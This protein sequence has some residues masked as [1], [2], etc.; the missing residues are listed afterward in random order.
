MHTFHHNE[1]SLSHFHNIILFQYAFITGKWRKMAE[2]VI[3][4]YASWESYTPFNLLLRVL[5]H[6]PCLP[7][8]AKDQNKQ[9]LN[10]QM[11][12]IR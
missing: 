11:N 5:I 9:M 3:D 12:M 7:I 8:H 2:D 6:V 10:N 1:I 4:R